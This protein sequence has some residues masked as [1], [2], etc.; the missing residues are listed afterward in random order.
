L[1]CIYFVLACKNKA[2]PDERND[3]V[4]LSNWA[5]VLSDKPDKR[6]SLS[7]KFKGE[8]K[9]AKEVHLGEIFTD[10]NGRLIVLGGSGEAIYM[11]PGDNK[12]P[13]LETEFDNKN[14]VDTTCDGHVEIKVIKKRNGKVVYDVT[15]GP[16]AKATVICTV[17]KFTP[18]IGPPTNLYDLIEDIAYK[19]LLR[20]DEKHKTKL[21]AKMLEVNYD[22]HV[23]PILVHVSNLAWVNKPATR[24][25]GKN[26][27][28]NEN[29]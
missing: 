17:P 16:E 10:K 11:G 12:F 3:L 4:I 5:T 13:P 27:N 19:R 29:Y 1:L 9:D 25:H 20:Y 18:G 2:N 26:K 21:A 28:R 22:E 6:V 7:G 8:Q 23:E 15:S 14:W 24:G